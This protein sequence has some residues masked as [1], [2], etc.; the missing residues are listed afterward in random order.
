MTP[1]PSFQNVHAKADLP[2]LT[3]TRLILH[4]IHLL[5]TMTPILLQSQWS[6]EMSIRR[7]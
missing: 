4:L 6:L 2:H 1:L 3:T 5:I 7:I